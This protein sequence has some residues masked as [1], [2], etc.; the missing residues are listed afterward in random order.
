MEIPIDLDELFLDELVGPVGLMFERTK[1][2]PTQKNQI[3]DC[4]QN[5]QQQLLLKT[6]HFLSFQSPQKS[7]N[8][9]IEAIIF[10]HE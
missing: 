5:A 1:F 8:Y 6:V 9:D 10:Q 4:I 2:R 7:Q 3:S